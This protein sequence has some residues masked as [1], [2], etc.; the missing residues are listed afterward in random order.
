MVSVD[1]L[2]RGLL[3]VEVKAPTIIAGTSSTV[4]IIIQNPF[5]EVVVIESIQAPTSAPLIPERKSA[6]SAAQKREERVIAPQQQDLA[7]FEIKTAHWLL[8]TPKNLELHA[9]IRYPVGDKLRSQTVPVTIS[10]QPPVSAVVL[11][12]ISGAVLGYFAR[13]LNA[14]LDLET[15]KPIKNRAQSGRSDRDGS[16][17]GNSL[18]ASGIIKGIRYPRGFLWRVRCRCNSRLRRYRVFRRCN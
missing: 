12:S 16:Y 5:P 11:G 14:G 9:L 17:S 8:V 2:S 1:V 7:S 4:S 18:V 6:A 10:I 13:V 15:V 3:S